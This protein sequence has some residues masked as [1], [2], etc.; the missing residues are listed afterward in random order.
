ML[1]PQGPCP[2]LSPDTQREML[3][4]I[5]SPAPRNVSLL[6]ILY[7]TP[8]WALWSAPAGPPSN[9]Y[10]QLIPHFP[11]ELPGSALLLGE[12][13]LVM[14]GKVEDHPMDIFE[15]PTGPVQP[16]PSVHPRSFH[17]SGLLD[18]QSED[19][20]SNLATTA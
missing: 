19:P 5:A 13:E 20:V 1:T 10:P 4:D 17:P 3:Q 18:L 15:H 7:S 16:L 14:A 6:G 12:C 2:C 11:R 8:T 9:L